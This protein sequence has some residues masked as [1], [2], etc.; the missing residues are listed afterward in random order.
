CTETSSCADAT[1]PVFAG[2]VSAT[3]TSPT[4]VDVCW[5]PATDAATPAGSIVYEVYDAATAGGQSFARAAPDAPTGQS[6]A[7]VTVPMAQQTCFVVRARDLAGNRDANT[8]SRC[9]TPGGACFAYD[10]VVQ[11]VFDARCVHCH[12]GSNP[13][14]GIRWDTYAH[15]IGNT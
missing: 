9:A 13:P 8:V 14:E 7:T 5:N 10:G 12:S 3:A 15:T 4:T 1:P 6:C 11:P 2:A